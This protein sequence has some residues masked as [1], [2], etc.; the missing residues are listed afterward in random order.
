MTMQ[1]T[2]LRSALALVPSHGKALFSTRQL[3]A[4]GRWLSAGLLGTISAAS[5]AQAEPL[6]WWQ[7][8]FIDPEDG[9]FD[10][11]QWLAR[12]GFIPVPVIL[13]E[14]AVGGGLGLMFAF[15]GQ[16][17]PA[18]D[19]PPSVTAIGG[20]ATGNG[21]K[22]YGGMHNGTYFA[23]RLKLSG[24]LS[25]ADVNLDFFT[26]DS[27]PSTY[28]FDG[29]LGGLTATYRLGQSQWYA[30]GTLRYQNLDVALTDSPPNPLLPPSLK[31]ELSGVG[32]ILDYAGLDNEFSPGS[33]TS[34][35]L[36][37]VRFTDGEDSEVD[38]TRAG[39]SVFSYTSPSDQLTLGGKFAADHVTGTVPFYLLPA[40][41]LR[42]IPANR[43]QGDTA[44][45]V[46]LEGS[47]ALAKRWRAVGF[48]GSGWVD[49]DYP[50]DGDLKFI[51]GAG[52]RYRIA[53]ALGVDVGIDIARGPEDTVVYIQFGRAWQRF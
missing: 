18:T 16:G 24:Y 3:R 26:G 39:L 47:Y 42:G 11:S 12:G 35:R 34:A 4:L 21:S 38:F 25:Q 5:M 27:Y 36:S 31:S 33:G 22:A 9:A 17:N 32:L 43:Y 10:A 19:T 8:N 23:G 14:P 45:S 30:G 28:N 52:F 13:S 2:P 50:G 7:R 37:A 44:I 49:A 53:R 41:D 40:I 29:L 20:V 6:N 51:Y 48:V 1:I 46:E 15:V